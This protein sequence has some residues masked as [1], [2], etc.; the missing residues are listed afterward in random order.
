ML[1]RSLQQIILIF[2][3]IILCQDDRLRLKQA[4]LLENKNIEG[5]A[6]QFLT[7]N[8]I[9]TKGKMTIW[10]DRAQY[11]EKSGQGVLVGNVT[12][13]K[14]TQSLTADSVKYDSP[15][16]IF[17]CYKSVHIWDE[18][19]DLTA[20]TVIYY[21]E[22]D[23]GIANGHSTMIQEGQEIT[24]H[25]LRYA[26][27]EE[28]DG[29]S[30][31]AEKDVTIIEG[32]RTATCGLAVYD[33][34]NDRTWL[35]VKP[36]LKEEGRILEGSEIQMF[37]ENDVLDYLF[38]PSN[39]HAVN[40]ASGF[41]EVSPNKN[42]TTQIR[43]DH[44]EFNDDMSGSTLK[45]YFVKGKLDSV[46]LEGMATTLYHIFEDSVYQGNNLT[47]GDTI[48]L[49]FKEMDSVEVDLESIH[50]S[51]GSRGVYTP[52]TTNREMDTPI[53]YTSDE[54]L[55]DMNTETTNLIG[56]ANIKYTDVDLTSG[57]I[58]VDWNNNLLKAFPTA[59]MDTTATSQKP[60]IVEQGRDPMVGDSLIYNLKSRK[61]RVKR[62]RSQADDGY[63][64][65]NEI[66]NNE[67][68]IYY[69]ENSSYTTCNQEIPHFH[70]ESTNMKIINQDK[71]IARPIV[72]Y[73]SRIPILGLPF[74]IFP[75]KS[76]GRHSGWIM[77][78][79]GENSVRGQYI[80]NLGY[81]WAPSDHWGTKFTMSFGDRQ[82]FVFNL[83]NHYKL[84]YKF[85][86]SLKLQSRQLLSNTSNISDIVSERSSSYQIRWNH[87][88]LLRNHQSLNVSANY[89]SSGEFSRKYTTDP[90]QRMSQQQTISN[91]TYSK[92][93]PSLQASMSMNLS[94]KTNLMADDKIDTNSVFYSKPSRLGMQTN[95]TTSTLP[96]VNFNLGQRNL[97]PSK[98]GDE[99]WFNNIKWR[100]NTSLT[101]K[102]RLYYESEQIEIDDTTSIF[103]WK[104]DK[105]HF[106]DNVMRHSISINVP[107]KILKYI[108][109]NPS[110]SIR[111]DWVNRTF[112]GSLDSTTNS[113]VSEEV[114]GFAARTTGSM[115]ASINTQIYGLFPINLGNIIAVRHVISPSIGYSFKPDFSK[116]FFGNDLG[117]F[118]TILDTAENTLYH[119]RFSGTMAG[120]TS[121]NESQSMNFSVN[122]N[123]QAKIREG[124][125]EKNITLFSWRFS[126]AYN[127]VAEQFRMNNLS[128]SIRSKVGQTNVDLRMTHDF[129]EFDKELGIRVNQIRKSSDGIPIP[130]LTK[131]DL[132]TG[133]QLSGSRFGS[134]SAHSDRSDLDTLLNSKDLSINKGKSGS[135]KLWSTRFSMGYSLQKSN[136]IFTKETFWMN[137]N[138]TLHVT[139]NWRVSYNARFD[140]LNNELISHRFSIYRD[141]HCWELAMDWTPSGYA[142]GFYLRIN[143]K[144]PTL[145]DLKV[146]QRGGHNRSVPF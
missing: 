8:V 54:I 101:N 127:F 96:S 46:R 24:A 142:S 146:E 91:A 120:G 10:C 130:R 35:K 131:M 53:T 99:R 36:K 73:I 3:I 69:I 28:E 12:M 88:Q 125:K 137:T 109:F 22:L 132:S 97:I 123:F 107:T 113:I 119:D 112:S 29:V 95:I 76:G 68:K 117:Y 65:G 145:R 27:N 133:F 39:A 79:Y 30:Y 13:E 74:G 6:T 66:R 31:T 105:K 42:D 104:N 80:N 67:K 47:S 17:T 50:I 116:P 87:V 98:G 129:Y 85:N 143:V 18:D 51:G 136:P 70:F 77:P 16:D 26:K 78:G 92:R 140:M 58:N 72:L 139:K 64:S 2:P 111:S 43:R 118:E 82:G 52:D 75:H 4:D 121:R 106:S 93:W 62:G 5:L 19:Y 83:N 89:S 49:S 15:N 141:L 57:F 34:Q 84:R 102:E 61:G 40:S 55:Y 37:Y 90:Q 7:G 32:G 108:T 38:I 9:F 124:D 41:R 94:S 25:H 44:V 100:Y 134:V 45:G 11:N 115:S 48:I 144:S 135:G 114:S 59:P 110:M 128:S 103:Q 14:E 33:V 60:A 20:D 81:Y 1:A 86:G 122:N 21:S 56:E 138:S 63:Y 71:V 126:S 23:S